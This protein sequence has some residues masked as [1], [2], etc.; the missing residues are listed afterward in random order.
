MLPGV[1]LEKKNDDLMRLEMDRDHGI[2]QVS[3][4]GGRNQ[5]F[6]DNLTKRQGCK[7]RN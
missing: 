2:F 7:N 5:M 6:L 3:E 1:N 4:S